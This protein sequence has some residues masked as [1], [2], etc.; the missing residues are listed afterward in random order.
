MKSQILFLSLVLSTNLFSIERPLPV[1]EL[2]AFHISKCQIDYNDKEQALQ[3]TMHLFIDDLEE[4]LKK[5]GVDKLFIGTERESKNAD[6]HL[7]DYIQNCFKLQV[8]DKAQDYVFIG[9]EP[10]EDLQAIWCYLE[11]TGIEKVKSIFVEN[12][13]ITEIYEDQKNII[14]I[15]MPDKKQGYFILEKGKSS[16]KVNF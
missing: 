11:I 13:I 1:E 3:I 12:T 5:Q 6:K 4:A 15:M 9:K 7:F 8:N 16:D 10:S 14:H 2:H